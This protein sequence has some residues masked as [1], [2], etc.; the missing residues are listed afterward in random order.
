[1]QVENVLVEEIVLTAPNRIALARAVL[2]KFGKRRWVSQHR[3]RGSKPVGPMTLFDDDEGRDEVAM[4]VKRFGE[5]SL[6]QEGSSKLVISYRE[7]WTAPPWT[8]F[9]LVLPSQF[10]ASTMTLNLQSDR[11]RS[12]VLQ[13][14][15]TDKNQLFYHA[16]L[17]HADVQ[18]VFDVE[19]RIEENPNNFSTMVKSS[20][21]VEG[22]SDFKMLG[23]AVGQKAL[24]PDFWLKLLELGGKITGH[25]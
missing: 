20:Q 2:Y 4:K 5:R 22:T 9:A 3:E 14:G 12:P 19:A 1:M 25:H 11:D 18:H 7:T 15:V 21:A 16:V 17:G 10:I 23:R 8:I 13:I 24:T 6:H